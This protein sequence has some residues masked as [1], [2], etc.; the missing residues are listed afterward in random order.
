MSTLGLIKDMPHT[1]RD[2]TT[3]EDTHSTRGDF[4]D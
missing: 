1:Y 4:E 2:K 3:D